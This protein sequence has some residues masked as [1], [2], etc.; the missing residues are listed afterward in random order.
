LW[1][2]W[3]AVSLT[4]VAANYVVFGADGFQKGP[5]G[6]VS[7]AARALLAP[8]LIGVW[9]N[10]RAR[11]RRAPS[12]VSVADGVSLGCLPD[13]RTAAGFAT[14][15]DLC[16][17]LPRLNQHVGWRAFP[18]LDLVVPEPRLLRAAAEAIEQARAKGTVLVCCALGYSRSAA[19]LATWLVASGRADNT[20]SAV[21]RIRAVRARIVLADDA[22]TAIARA[23]EPAP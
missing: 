18:T 16:A 20:E 21:E 1:L 3:P 9:I 14:V 15:V 17:E 5:D 10:S 7:L 4:L 19:A 11:T 2:L 6:H 22:L 12:P 13:G 23:A 8:Y